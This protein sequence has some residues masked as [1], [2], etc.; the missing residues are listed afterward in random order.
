M[1]FFISALGFFIIKFSAAFLAFFAP[2]VLIYLK[3]KLA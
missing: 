2:E 3:K 1:P